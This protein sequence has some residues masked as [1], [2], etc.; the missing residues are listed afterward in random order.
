M[1]TPFEWASII[2]GSTVL[3]SAATALATRRPSMAKV[4]AENYRDVVERLS[5]VEARLDT[6]EKDLDKERAD[7]ASTRELL[8]TCLR[9]IREAVA[10]AAGPRHTEFP[11]PPAELVKEL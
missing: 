3:S 6:V 4:F 7:H 9:W 8:R 1:M 10:W 11:T 2:A 5:K